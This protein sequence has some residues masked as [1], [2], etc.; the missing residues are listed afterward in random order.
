MREDRP[1]VW[2]QRA[3]CWVLRKLGATHTYM[4]EDYTYYQV[5][6]TDLVDSFKQQYSDVIYTTGKTPSKVVMGV[7]DFHRLTYALQM[8]HMLS[9]NLRAPINTYHRADM[10]SIP[11][12]VLPWMSGILV[13]P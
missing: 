13:L 10:M 11:V 4:T 6:V 5:D 3:C 9:F 8:N 1:H 7:D 2:L 12:M